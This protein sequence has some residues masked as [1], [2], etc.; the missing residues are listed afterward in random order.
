MNSTKFFLHGLDSSG[1]GTKGQFFAEH[2]PDVICPDFAG[3]L[4]DRLEQLTRICE[5]KSHM[6]LIGSSFGGLMATCFA[7]DHSQS[8]TRLILLA[9][10]LNFVDFKPPKEKITLQTLLVIGAHDTV[11]P[12]AQVIPLANQT[13]ANLETR[14]V[15]DDH[16]L[17]KSFALIEWASLLA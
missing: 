9:P 13:F 10:A 5:G 4:A 16:F 12:P 7:L 1:K 11:T 15:D 14:I 2:Y 8:I 3:N 6:I 17:R